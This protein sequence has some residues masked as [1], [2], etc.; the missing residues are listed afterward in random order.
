MALGKYE[1]ASNFYEKL[2]T[3][4]WPEYK[5]RAG[6]LGGRSLLAQKKY[7]EAQAKFD[8]VLAEAKNANGKEAEKQAL[9]ATLG[10]AVAVAGAGNAEEALEV[11]QG[12]ID[13]AAKDDNEIMARA[14]NAQGNCYRMAGKSKEAWL[15]FLHVD[16]LPYSSVGEQHAE[17]LANLATL[18]GEFNKADRGNAARRQLKEQYPGSPWTAAAEKE[19]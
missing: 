2:A 8:D 12:V 16:V 18:W 3:A 15:A 6:I 1:Q 4:P 13:Q 14:Y 11:I 19:K 17:A 10:R 9:E 5:M 7:K